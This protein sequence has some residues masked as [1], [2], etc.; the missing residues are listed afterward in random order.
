MREVTGL[1]L[2]Q[3]GSGCH[4]IDGMFWHHNWSNNLR[5]W[6]TVK[7]WQSSWEE[8]RQTESPH[9]IWIHSRQFTSGGI[10]F[11]AYFRSIPSFYL[12]S[13]LLKIPPS[14]SRLHS[15]HHH[16]QNALLCRAESCLLGS[17]PK[18]S[19]TVSCFKQHLH[20][21]LVLSAQKLVSLF[22]TFIHLHYLFFCSSSKD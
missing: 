17:V 9:F 11:S 22:V 4:G 20:S 13:A 16:C 8:W 12:L 2:K 5:V 7:D 10:V 21:N 3:L 19:I 6:D 1:L 14:E 15:D 18:F